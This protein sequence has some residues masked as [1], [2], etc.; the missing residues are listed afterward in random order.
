MKTKIFIAC[1]VFCS[2]WHVDAQTE[3]APIGA[4]WYYTFTVGGENPAN[5]FNHVVSEK[6]TTIEG[7]NCRIL[8]QYYDYSEI[9]NEK[10]IIQ[11]E[12]GK[13]YYYYQEQFNLLFDF[14][15]EA[16]DTVKF[17]FKY[18]KYNFDNMPLYKDTVLSARYE[19]EAITT[20]SHYLKIFKSKIL[21]EDK[22]IVHNE[23]VLPIF[24]YYTEKTGYESVFIPMF[25]NAAHTA[26]SHFALRCYSDANLSLV[27]DWWNYQSLP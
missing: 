9:A 11:Q 2:A 5:H 15:A 14:D 4:E 16:G 27:S 17:T 24:Y 13:V 7:N 20:N 18:Q 8:R 19:I 1:L 21:E 12:Q 3:F 22:Y 23:L 10:Y 26:D 25:D 6:D